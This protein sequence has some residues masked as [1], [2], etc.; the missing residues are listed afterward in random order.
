M[1]A[2]QA[3]QV[4]QGMRLEPMDPYTSY[5]VVES[6]YCVDGIITIQTDQTTWTFQP[7]ELVKFPRRPDGDKKLWGIG[8]EK[9]K[10]DE[11]CIG[12]II[13]PKGGWLDADG[14]ITDPNEVLW[15]GFI[16]SSVRYSP[17]GRLFTTYRIG[18]ET[19]ASTVTEF[20]IAWNTEIFHEA[21][22]TIVVSEAKPEK[23]PGNVSGYYINRDKGV[24][25]RFRI[26]GALGRPPKDSEFAPSNQADWEQWELMDGAKKH[27]R[28]P[29]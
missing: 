16:V 21:G 29:R 11:I 2:K 13:P 19:V 22:T 28:D 12:D 25:T 6:I 24:R 14:N 17:L 15:K 8:G 27:P 18:S 26:A 7:L 10:V 1:A 20:L 4:R 3:W 5:Q 23:Q 9:V